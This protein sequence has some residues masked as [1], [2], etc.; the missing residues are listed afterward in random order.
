[1]TESINPYKMRRI[2]MSDLAHNEDF[3][4]K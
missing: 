3:A 1:M 2:H 4:N